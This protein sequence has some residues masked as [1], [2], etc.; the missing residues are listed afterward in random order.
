[1]TLDQSSD[2]HFSAYVRTDFNK[3]I[4]PSEY[5]LSTVKNGKT[6]LIIPNQ[7]P[8]IFRT[9]MSS[10]ILASKTQTI[11]NNSFDIYNDN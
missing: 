4:A 9:E 7:S 11:D 2:P 1:M 5:L 6:G 10:D 3:D 8:Q